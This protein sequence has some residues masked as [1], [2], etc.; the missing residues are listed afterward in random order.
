LKTAFAAAAISFFLL[1]FTRWLFFPSVLDRECDGA[2]CATQSD[3]KNTDSYTLMTQIPK[4]V[5]ISAR[6]RKSEKAHFGQFDCASVS[7]LFAFF[8]SFC[9]FFFLIF[10][11]DK[12]RSYFK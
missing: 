7:F 1:P 6:R 3:G 2:V 4:Y 12:L 5:R 8:L 10:F 11:F 9:F